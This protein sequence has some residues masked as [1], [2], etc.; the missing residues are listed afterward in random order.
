[1]LSISCSD[2]FCEVLPT[3]VTCCGHDGEIF[4]PSLRCEPCLKNPGV[5]GRAPEG[6]REEICMVIFRPVTLAA[7]RLR[8]HQPLRRAGFCRRS[9]RLQSCPLGHRKSPALGPRRQLGRSTCLP[10][11]FS[12][13]IRM[14]SLWSGDFE[15]K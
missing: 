6:T 15:L 5:R 1:L 7:D 8:H 9:T 13:E 2:E 12:R 11:S 3:Q 14:L 10:P 4:I